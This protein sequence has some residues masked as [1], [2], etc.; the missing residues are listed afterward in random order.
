MNLHISSD[1]KNYQCSEVDAHAEHLSSVAHQDQSTPNQALY[2][3]LALD[4]FKTVHKQAKQ[5]K[6][7]N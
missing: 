4:K 3:L 5:K 2:L 7:R 1:N 6:E